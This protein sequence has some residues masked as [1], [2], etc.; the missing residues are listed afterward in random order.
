MNN[1]T[2]LPDVAS[3]IVSDISLD[4]VGMANIALP[5]RINV[6]NGTQTCA[7][8]AAIFANVQNGQKG[9]HMSRMYESLLEL[10]ETS[11]SA[12]TLASCAKHALLQQTE[13]EATN[14]S[15]ELK[16]QLQIKRPALNSNGDGWNRYPVEINANYSHQDGFTLSLG[17]QVTYSSSCPASAALSRQAL[18]QTFDQT[19]RDSQSLNHG[20]ITSWLEK[21]GTLAIPHSQRSIANITVGI[22]DGPLPISELINTC[23]EALGTPVQT[24]VKRDDEQEFALRNGANPMFVEDASRRLIQALETQGYS[25]KLYVSHQESLHGHDAVAQAFFSSEER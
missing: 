22:T 16:T 5:L 8:N 18:S 17:I 10:S 12:A 4:Q 11:L 23:E 2:P 13:V 19:F 21:N 9:L 25:G 15:I 7:A 24:F 14:L 3:K 6:E 1:L 20:E